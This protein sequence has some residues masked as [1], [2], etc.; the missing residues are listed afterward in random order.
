MNG[1]LNCTASGPHFNPYG[2]IK[3][4]CYMIYFV[5]LETLHGPPEA[6]IKHRHVGDLGNLTAGAGGVVIIELTDPIISLYD[7]TRSIA[8]RTIVLHAMRD[9]G[10]KGGFPD[11]N[12]TGY[13]FKLRKNLFS[14]LHCFFRNAGPRIACGVITL[15]MEDTNPNPHP[16]K[17]SVSIAEVFRKLFV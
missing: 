9:D 5:Y 17:I 16:S 8:N 3:Q 12:T 13:L 15:T 6:D 4:S 11:S 14:K 1:E 2:K 10:G 7:A